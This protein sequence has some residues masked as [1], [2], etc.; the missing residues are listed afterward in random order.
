MKFFKQFKI[1][2]LFLVI[3]FN[4]IVAAENHGHFNGTNSQ[5]DTIKYSE[6]FVFQTSGTRTSAY[7]LHAFN[8]LSDCCDNLILDLLLKLLKQSCEVSEVAYNRPIG[9]FS[10]FNFPQPHGPPSF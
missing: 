5:N 4:L 7:L 8:G 10:K 3:S 9:F 1:F 2:F 6:L